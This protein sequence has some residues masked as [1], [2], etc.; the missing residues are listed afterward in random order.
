[1]KRSSLR[2]CVGFS[3]F[4]TF[5]R[6]FNLKLRRIHRFNK[7]SDNAVDATACNILEKQDYSKQNTTV[8]VNTSLTCVTKYFFIAAL[9]E[10]SFFSDEI[11][12]ALFFSLV[13]RWFFY[14]F[15]A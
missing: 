5:H 3:M 6:C 9:F 13:F 14:H 8:T 7:F 2:P 12:I 4:F 10:T 15:C 11:V 1:M